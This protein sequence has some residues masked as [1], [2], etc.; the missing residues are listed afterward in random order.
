MNDKYRSDA[1]QRYVSTHLAHRKAPATVQ[2]FRDKS[3]TWDHHFASFL[4]DDR[5]TPILDAGCGRG[6]LVWWLQSLGFINAEGVDVSPE[7]I[8][9]ARSL[10]VQ[11]V[12]CGDLKEYLDRRPA[13]YGLVTMRDV[14]EHFD[15]PSIASILTSVHAALR[16]G[17]L[18]V[19]QVPNAESPF[20]GRT[21]YGDITHELSF[22][23]TSLSQIL[24]LGGFEPLEFRAVAPF[25]RGVGSLRR[26][27]A[28]RVVESVYRFFLAAELGKAPR[29]VTQ[30]LIAAATKP[31]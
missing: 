15:R 4:P 1:F 7:V 13:H 3:V 5:A 17:G 28:W 21:R 25:Y 8:D 9:V 30:N 16:P 14:L 18:L 6:S 31:R 27:V 2:Q 12:E 10:G 29:I 26:V 20:A 24:L 22:T 19:L 11:N 23:T